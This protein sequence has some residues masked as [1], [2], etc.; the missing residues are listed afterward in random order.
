MSDFNRPTL[1]QLINDAR[2]DLKGRL[3]GADSF[4]RRSVVGVLAIV[5]GGMIHGLYGY[6]AFV[7]KQFFPDTATGTWLTR[8]ASIYGLTRKAGVAASGTIT[9]T[10]TA[11]AVIPAG[12]ELQRADEALF[13]TDAQLTLTGTS[14]AVSVTAVTP[15]ADGNTLAGTALSFTSPVANVTSDATVSVAISGGSDAE[16]DDDLRSRLLDHIRTPPQGGADADYKEW[17]GSVT[18]VTRVWPYPLWM[19]PGTVGI[20]FVCDAR[21]DIIPTAADIAAVKAVIDVKRPVTADT[22]VFAPIATVQNYQMSVS[23][24]TDTVKAAVIAQMEDFYTREAEPGG[25]I[26]LSR[27]NEAISAAPGETD[28]VIVS[29]TVNP[30]TTS[31]HM[32]ILGTVTWI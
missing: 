26:V 27:L 28:H 29:P 11:G 18:G 16:S 10:G 1:S 15:G 8:W 17:A 22:Y 30:T 3:T 6:V 12:S 9:V 24:S 20:T 19:G 25:T 2:N 14:G 23:P 13:K 4:L 5:L 32:P 21:D 31:G 7:I